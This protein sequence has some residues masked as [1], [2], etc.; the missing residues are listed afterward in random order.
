MVDLKADDFGGL[1]YQS[2]NTKPRLNFCGRGAS[3]TLLN[4][5]N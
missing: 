4:L 1:R 2:F 5:D 3:W